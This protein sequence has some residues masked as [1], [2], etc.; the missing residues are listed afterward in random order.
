MSKK[1]EHI[2]RRSACPGS[3]VLQKYRGG[4][5]L[6]AER[7]AVEDHLAHCEMCSDELEG[8]SLLPSHNHLSTIEDELRQKLHTLIHK[9]KKRS[10]PFIYRFSI[11]A[12][13]LLIIGFSAWMYIYLHQT[14]LP[15]V[16]VAE[17]TESKAPQENEKSTTEATTPPPP[18]KPRASR[19]IHSEP[20]SKKVSIPMQTEPVKEDELVVN[21]EEVVNIKKRPKERIR[22]GNAELDS[23]D[24]IGSLGHLSKGQADS[25][26]GTSTVAWSPAN[27]NSR[28]GSAKTE[29]KSDLTTPSLASSAELAIGSLS[30]GKEVDVYREPAAPLAVQEKQTPASVEG[31]RAEVN[32]P[33]SQYAD[34]ARYWME[35]RNAAKSLAALD[36]LYTHASPKLQTQIL[37]I[38][39]LIKEAEFDKALK[40]LFNLGK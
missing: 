28:Y 14:K 20:V 39:A 15:N 13:I 32:V 2:I 9:E 16:I 11:A 25:L 40:A 17:Q 30:K 18:K 35:K 37:K 31:K 38:K 34:S 36:S 21:A 4:E 26:L 24:V 19:K 3:E 6:P 1:W 23:K 5:L 33:Q 29:S 27:S 7:F 10:L 12:S 8:L 22:I